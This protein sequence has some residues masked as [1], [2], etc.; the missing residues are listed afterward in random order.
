MRVFETTVSKRRRILRA[1]AI[2]VLNLLIWIVVPSY[3]GSVLLRTLPSTPLAIPAFV[4]TFGATITALE[5]AA[6]LTEGMEISVPFVTATHL[7]TAYYLWVV[8]EGGLISVVANGAHVLLYFTPI[9]YILLVPSLFGAAKA[10]LAYYL[11]RR[12]MERTIPPV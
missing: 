1:T 7:M 2:L 10:P 6:A 5:V 11:Q 12:A 9:V 8:T 3:L 4:Y